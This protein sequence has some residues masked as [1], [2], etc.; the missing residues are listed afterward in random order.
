M[1]IG[2]YVSGLAI[3]PVLIG[4][5]ILVAVLGLAL[6]VQTVRLYKS[7]ASETKAVADLKVANN[8]KTT[9]INNASAAQE[10]ATAWETTAKDFKSRLETEQAEQR[11]IAGENAAAVAQS[12]QREKLLREELD[13][14][15]RG[16]QDARKKPDCLKFLEMPICPELQ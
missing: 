9:A 1:S 8:D 4:S 11:R 5:A 13:R 15:K 2:S 12:A 10:S 16:T 7:Q 14:K 3:K 6:G